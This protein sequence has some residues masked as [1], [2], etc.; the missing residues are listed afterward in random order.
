M[1]Q[2]VI[3]FSLWGNNMN[4]CIGAIKNADLA[5]QFYP[6]F[7]CWFYIHQPTVPIETINEL[8]TK[9]NV[10]IILNSYDLYTSKPMMWR[11]FP[12]LDPEVELT[13]SRD[14]DSRIL[15]REKLAVE[16]WIKSDSIF[17]IMRDHPHH[18][19]K[20]P[21]GMF[22]I[23]KSHLSLYFNGME[24]FKQYGVRNY[25]Q[26]FLALEIYPKIIQ[27]CMIHAN[28]FKIENNLCKPFPIPYDKDYKFV[29]EYVYH[30]DSRSIGH[31]NL[32]KNSLQNNDL[33]IDIFFSL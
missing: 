7:D 11:F 8:K 15:L 26:D 1:S 19:F 12:I 4:Y 6:N 30:D 22:G 10:K 3:S 32:L 29:G 20:I 23:K 31:I 27:S 33:N 2:K 25:D 9:K 14:T 17:H 24:K 18:Q 28:F 5:K 21:G 16:E 13:M